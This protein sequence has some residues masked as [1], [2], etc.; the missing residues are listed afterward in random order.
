M[1]ADPLLRWVVTVLFVVAAGIFVT[2]LASGRASGP[3]RV[4]ELLHVVMAVAMAVMAWP[5]GAD[6]PTTGPMIFFLLAMMWFVTAAVIEPDHWPANIYHAAMMLAMGWMYAAMNGQILPGH[7]GGQQGGGHG[8]HGAMPGMAMPGADGAAPADPPYIGAVNW[9]WTV[10]FAA[11]A[12]WWLYRCIPG[13]R[14]GGPAARDGWAGPAAQA[15]MAA[16][17]AIMFAVML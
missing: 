4:S 3:R 16:G 15:M 8:H 9:L 10:G 14:A 13:R 17:M 1:I 11:A 6:L 7:G 2:A 12:L 5:R